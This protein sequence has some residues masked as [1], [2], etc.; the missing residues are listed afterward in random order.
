MLIRLFDEEPPILRPAVCYFIDDAKTAKLFPAQHILVL[1]RLPHLIC[2]RLVSVRSSRLPFKNALGW[3]RAFKSPYA[4][5]CRV[6]SNIPQ[7][8]LKHFFV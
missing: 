2:I 6:N 7:Y 4:N 5:A 3:L 1:T 8:F